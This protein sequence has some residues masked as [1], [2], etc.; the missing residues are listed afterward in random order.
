VIP[1]LGVVGEVEGRIHDV[2]VLW[3]VL[4]VEVMFAPIQPWERIA[5][6]VILWELHFLCGGKP[7]VILVISLVA[8]GAL[9]VKEANTHELLLLALLRECCFNGGH[10]IRLATSTMVSSF[11]SLAAIPDP[12]PTAEAELMA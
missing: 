11:T 9:G 4:H 1:Q 6:A 10:L 3:G 7:F 5:H 8:R 12:P 2:S